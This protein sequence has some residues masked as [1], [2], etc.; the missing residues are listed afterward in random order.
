MGTD[1]QREIEDGNRF[2]QLAYE[3][4]CAASGGRSLVSGDQLPSWDEQKR[5]R[6]KIADAWMAVGLAVAQ[7]VRTRG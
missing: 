1:D 6:P 5:M 4:Y 3:T 7:E 2:G